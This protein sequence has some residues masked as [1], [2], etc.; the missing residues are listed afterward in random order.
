LHRPFAKAI[1]THAMEVVMTRLCQ[2]A[3]T[4]VAAAVISAGLIGCTHDRPDSLSAN[5][6]LGVEGDRNLV[7]TAPNDG[8]VTV[9]DARTDTILYTGK[10]ARGDSVVADVDNNRI[11]LNGRVVAEPHLDRLHEHRLYFEPGP[12]L[13]QQQQQQQQD[14]TVTHTTHTESTHSEDSVH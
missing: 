9:Y 5:A 4:T 7:Y 11:T 12:S 8:I 2:F 13:V 6:V 1:L 10:V 3:A 14:T